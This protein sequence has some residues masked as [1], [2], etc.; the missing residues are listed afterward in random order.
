M[1]SKSVVIILLLLASLE[2]VIS[3]K[4]SYDYIACIRAICGP[5]YNYKSVWYQEC[6]GEVGYPI[7]SKYL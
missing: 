1:L 6:L 3:R 7:C 2:F 4:P 5:A